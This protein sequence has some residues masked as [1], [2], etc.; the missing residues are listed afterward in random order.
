VRYAPAPL[1]AQ[2]LEQIARTLGKTCA[3]IRGRRCLPEPTGGSGRARVR[4]REQIP[5]LDRRSNVLPAGTQ[6]HGFAMALVLLFETSLNE[7]H[8][9]PNQTPGSPWSRWWLS[10]RGGLP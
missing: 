10:Q 5:D 7:S 8:E 6:G 4:A 2:V 3:A 1:V 9:R